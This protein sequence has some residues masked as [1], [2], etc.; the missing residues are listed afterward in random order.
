MSSNKQKE[1]RVLYITHNLELLI[2]LLIILFIIIIGLVFYNTNIKHKSNTYRIFMPDVDGLIVGSP[3]R[4]MGIEVGHVTKIKPIHNQE[5]YVKFILNDKNIQIPQGTEITVEFSGIA[6]SK[7]LEIYLPQ[8]DKYIDNSTPILQV[9]PPKRLH[10]AAG[11]LYDMFNKLGNI[12]KTS[13]WFGKNLDEIDM[14]ETNNKND[15]AEDFVNYADGI[16]D[17]S[18]ERMEN[19]GRKLRNGRQ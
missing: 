6:G 16:V 7:S 12:I 5:V 15:S 17:K 2:W 9:N 11:L 8:D 1:N 3:V 13:S 18:Q 4:M 10:D 19:L 14:P